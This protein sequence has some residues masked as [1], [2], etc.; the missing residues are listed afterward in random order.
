[1]LLDCGEMAVHSSDKVSDSHDLARIV[2]PSDVTNAFLCY[3][4]FIAN[5]ALTFEKNAAVVQFFPKNVLLEKYGT[6]S[7]SRKVDTG[8]TKVF[9]LIFK[10]IYFNYDLFLS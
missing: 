1:M 5:A 2:I 7:M 10:L 3:R 8:L 4:T 6:N 9:H